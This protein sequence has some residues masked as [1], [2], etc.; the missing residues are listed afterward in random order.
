MRGVKGKEARDGQSFLIQ[1]QNNNLKKL[2]GDSS[3]LPTRSIPMTKLS[4][5]RFPVLESNEEEKDSEPSDLNNNISQID[6]G[7]GSSR[8][9]VAV[10]Y[11]AQAE[12][13]VVERVMVLLATIKLPNLS[14]IPCHAS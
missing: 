8:M 3:G 1:K 13:G 7:K 9:E 4:L 6:N 11:Q 12:A 10:G 2:K 5:A 14:R